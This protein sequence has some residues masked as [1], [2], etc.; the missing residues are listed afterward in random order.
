MIEG[1][2]TPI[3]GFAGSLIAA[4]GAVYLTTLKEKRNEKNSIELTLINFKDI[5]SE[6]L[7]PNLG[8]MVKDCD[9]IIKDIPNADILSIGLTDNI[10]LETKISNL[11]DQNILS[12]ALILKNIEVKY[13]IF[14]QIKMDLIYKRSPQNLV[15]NFNNSILQNKT[16]RRDNMQKTIEME[17]KVD[18][19]II[20]ESRENIDRIYDENINTFKL[21]TK[22]NLNQTKIAIE[23]LITMI[24]NDFLSKL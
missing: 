11:L 17:T 1:I 6:L 2:L 23:D 15:A 5:L 16:D 7:L 20:Q 22:T 24:N 18:S 9:I 13:L 4:F 21:T 19:V 3:I 14:L 12:K 8:E 10:F